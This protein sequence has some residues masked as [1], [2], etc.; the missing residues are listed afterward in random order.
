[1]WARKK[2]VWIGKRESEV[3]INKPLK[4]KWLQLIYFTIIS[5]I[6]EIDNRMLVQYCDTMYVNKSHQIALRFVQTTKWQ[7]KKK[8]SWC[9]CG[10]RFLI[11][12][13]K[14]FKSYCVFNIVSC[15]LLWV[16]SFKNAL[17]WWGRDTLTWIL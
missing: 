12:N 13:R 2:W 10:L 14:N 9:R 16:W 8:R 1:M 11:W 6:H 3:L 4:S 7:L 15:I 17:N 5:T